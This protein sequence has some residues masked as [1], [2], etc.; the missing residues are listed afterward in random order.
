MDSKNGKNIYVGTEVVINLCKNLHFG[1]DIRNK[2]HH[3]MM[4]EYVHSGTRRGGPG[5]SW[6]ISETASQP[7]HNVEELN[8]SLEN[9]SIQ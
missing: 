3:G 4:A 7:C 6:G 2:A 9:F 5:L 1:L 8:H